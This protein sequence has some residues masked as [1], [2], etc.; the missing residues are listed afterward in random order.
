MH[1]HRTSLF[2]ICLLIAASTTV[3]QLPPPKPV[4]ELQETDVEIVQSRHYTDAGSLWL[5]G[6]AGF[7]SLGTEDENGYEDQ[8]DRLSIFT[9]SPAVLFFPAKHFCLGPR[10]QYMS[11]SLGSASMSQVGWG[12]EAGW[13]YKKAAGPVVYL[14][15]GIQFDKETYSSAPSYDG[16]KYSESSELSTIPFAIGIMIPVGDVLA[17]QIEPGYTIKTMGKSS[18]NALSI[19]FGFAG[20]GERMCIST[21]QAFSNFLQ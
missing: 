20:I 11:Q 14:L 2:Q 7:Y 16:Y 15:T 1:R 12:I 4:P 21:T 6:S 10:F 13:V 5:S 18:M 3:A 17:I 9:V 8:D 19:S